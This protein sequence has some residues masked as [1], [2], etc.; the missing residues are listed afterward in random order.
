LNYSVFDEIT[1]THYLSGDAG[2]TLDKL[3][4]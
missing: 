4:K 2:N 3:S 1:G